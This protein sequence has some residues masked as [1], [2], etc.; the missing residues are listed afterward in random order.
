MQLYISLKWM[1]LDPYFI[2]SSFIQLLHKQTGA[3]ARFRALLEYWQY[4]PYFPQY[5]PKALFV[6]AS[7]YI[8]V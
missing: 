3:Q 5:L 8:M 6:L 2:H 4:M 7:R 1:T